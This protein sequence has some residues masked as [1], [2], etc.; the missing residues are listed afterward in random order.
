MKR[1]LTIVLAVFLTLFLA[2]VPALAA[3]DP[4]PLGSAE[5]FAVL[6]GT[7]VTNTGPSRISGDLGVFPGTA[8]TGFPPGLVMNGSIHSADALA[9]QAQ[10][11]LTTAYLDA[12]G[13]TP[14]TDLGA[15][16]VELGGSTL[17]S[18]VIGEE[19]CK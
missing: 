9:I 2:I 3:T 8:V 12:A 4:V 11:S 6:A 5:S 18:G 13:R 16:V 10:N 15:G 1:L 17:V 7:T 19:L 14:F